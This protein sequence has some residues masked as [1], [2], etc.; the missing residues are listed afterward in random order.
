MLKKYDNLNKELENLEQ[1]V[2]RYEQDLQE[3]IKEL[4]VTMLVTVFYIVLAV[5]SFLVFFK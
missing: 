1:F 2:R 3:D 4:H 5:I